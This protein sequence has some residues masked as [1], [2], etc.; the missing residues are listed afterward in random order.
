MK[1]RDMASLAVLALVPA[2]AIL[3]AHADDFTC[4]SG[5][6]IVKADRAGGYK[7]KIV[8]SGQ[9]TSYD[10]YKLT[11][12]PHGG[13]NRTELKLKG[14]EDGKATINLKHQGDY[15]LVLFGC[16][17]DQPECERSSEK[18]RMNLN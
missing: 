12:T 13:G 2:F 8:W 9:G 3:P 17:K 1:L 5:P 14:G 18:V 4:D 11:V 6:C 16:E 7:V 15:E 10:F